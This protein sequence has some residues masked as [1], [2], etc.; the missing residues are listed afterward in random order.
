M[1]EKELANSSA[2]FRYKYPD[3]LIRGYLKMI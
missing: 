3:G 1:D 2:R